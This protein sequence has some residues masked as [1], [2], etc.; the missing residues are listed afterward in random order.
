MSMYNGAIRRPGRMGGNRAGAGP[1]GNCKCPTCGRV[2]K[3]NTG[4]P[5]Y[6]LQCP[7][8]KVTLV[9]VL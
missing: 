6:Y 9:R 4:R 7:Q 8:C 5:C 2:Y 3:H 1:G